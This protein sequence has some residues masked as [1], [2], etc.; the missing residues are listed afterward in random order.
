MRMTLTGQVFALM[1]GVASSDQANEIIRS[2]DRYL[3]DARVGGYRLNTD[4]GEVLPNL[5]RAFGFA[6]GHKENGAMFSH[7][8]V[9]YAYALYQRGLV[10]QGFK[11]LEGIYKHCQQFSHSHIYPGIPEYFNNRG[12]GMYTYLT[13]SASWYM[14]TLVT[15]VFGARG[16]M[17]DLLLE[18]KLMAG[19]FD[20]DGK[21]RIVIRF[22]NRD[23]EITYHNPEGLEYGNYGIHSVSLDER[24]IDLAGSP[25]IIPRSL[26]AS[27]KPGRTYQVE[28]ELQR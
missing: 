14:L 26:I 15:E 19:Q 28:V 7:M 9:M 16:V 3:F 6:Y 5:G 21:A 4:F 27:L 13:G 12:R 11:V 24:L 23:L 2:A 8:A 22:A 25:V 10:K 18:P 1:G 17:G 20:S